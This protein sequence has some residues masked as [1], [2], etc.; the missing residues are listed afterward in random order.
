MEFELKR[1]SR[2]IE[3]EGFHNIYY[4]ELEKNFSH[5]PEKHD[6]WEMV[7]VIQGQ[8]NAITNG[9]GEIISEGQVLFQKPNELHAH[10]SDGNIGNKM[11]IVTFTAKGEAMN[12]FERKLFTLDK[13]QKNIL[14]LFI[15]EAKI[16]LGR[17][18][19]EYENKNPINFDKA[20][21]GSV[22]LLECY[23]IEFLLGLKRSCDDAVKPIIK[24]ETTLTLARNATAAL[25]ADYLRARLS[26]NVSLNELCMKFYMGK[27]QLCDIFSSYSEKGPIGYHNHLK[28]ERAK[29][30]L[31]KEKL[32][33]NKISEL[34]AFSSIHSFS[35]AFKN[36]V[37]CSPAEFRKKAEN[38]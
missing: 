7:F 37:G 16:A 36:A 33:V 6:F 18:S 10:I 5:V 35:R 25:I 4:F 19:G 30:L 9:V 29:E 32:S 14:S 15:N 1:I 22:Q 11:L 38:D 20:P 34:L 24:T 27:T 8:I 12:F 28:I 26:E 3:L 17:I 21:F 13:S 23:F 31:T 2:E